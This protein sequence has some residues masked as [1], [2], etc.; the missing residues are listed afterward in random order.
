MEKH[1]GID[2]GSVL[3]S[4]WCQVGSM[5]APKTDSKSDQ[6]C[7]YFLGNSKKGLRRLA[8]GFP[9]PTLPPQDT[10]NGVPWTPELES[11]TRREQ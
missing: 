7:D 5:L 11:S 10:I 2:L 9:R 1:L 4:F 6:F 3:V 8:G